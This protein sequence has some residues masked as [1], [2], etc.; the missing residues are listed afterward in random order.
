[1][2]ISKKILLFIAI[3][4]FIIAFSGTAGNNNKIIVTPSPVPTQM[5]ERSLTITATGDCTLA[6]DIT[7]PVYGSFESKISEVSHDYSYFL[8]NVA[9]IFSE[10]DLTIVNFEGTLSNNGERMDKQFAFRAN[11]EYVGILT[12]SSVE[13][14]N[15]ANN[16]SRDYGEISLTDTKATLTSAGIL[17]FLGEDTVITDINGIKVGLLGI[18]ALND[19]GIE[20][21]VPLVSSLKS[22][23][24]EII[25]LSIHWGIEKADT[26]EEYQ[27]DLAHL[28]IDN[29][30]DLVIGHHPHVLQ[31]VEKYKGRYI[32][33]SMG[34]FCFGGNTNPS[35]KDT[36]LVRATLTLDDAG[37]LKD[38]DNIC[39]IP[40]KISGSDYSNNYQPVIATGS[41]RDRIINKINERTGYIAP[42]ELKFR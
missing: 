41:E 18:N 32:M 6:T 21:V 40:C 37:N 22:S 39:F 13:A 26:P 36:M 3:L 28:A 10:D 20:S 25:I 17:N 19:T 24:C 34:N 31:G 27:K 38:D 23:G 42:L 5:P 11:P 29:G 16:H 9:P 15:L 7:T 12:T 14:A 35:D 30:A 4:L 1:M 8:R 2:S 33:Y